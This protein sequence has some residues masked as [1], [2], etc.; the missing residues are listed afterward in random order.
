MI[1]AFT[2]VVTAYTIL[3][4]MPSGYDVGSKILAPIVELPDTKS[5]PQNQPTQVFATNLTRKNFPIIDRIP[6]WAQGRIK[7]IYVLSPEDINGPAF[8]DAVKTVKSVTGEKL[9][10]AELT[11]YLGKEERHPAIVN[12]VREFLKTGLPEEVV[13][14]ITEEHLIDIT[15]QMASGGAANFRFNRD[16]TTS[17]KDFAIIATPF[18][19]ATKEEC[20]AQVAYLPASAVENISGEDEEH[21]NFIIMHETGHATR[22]VFNSD[23]AEEV[24]GDIDGNSFYTIELKRGTVKTAQVPDCNQKLRAIANILDPDTETQVHMTSAAI[25][26]EGEGP[27]PKGNAKQFADGLAFLK[28]MIANNIGAVHVGMSNYGAF[29]NNILNG[30][31]PVEGHEIIIHGT[32]DEKIIRGM[33]KSLSGDPEEYFKLLDQL[34]EGVK[35]KVQALMDDT[36][37]QQGNVIA[38]Y[39]PPLVYKTVADLYQQNLLDENPFGK[40]YAWEFLIAAQKHAAKYFEAE[41]APQRFVQPAFDEQGIYLTPLV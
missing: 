37:I 31:A 5:L 34:S 20:A 9:T 24:R 16:V 19:D 1:A 6:E 13:S 38:R 7:E 17:D 41:P 14:Y 21:R 33:L 18:A 40:Q 12:E 39:N 25:Q 28:T 36:N 26:S 27:A 3:E 32:S 29:L 23:L 4:I 30:V 10:M 11:A 35:E 15:N 22:V 2:G 8:R